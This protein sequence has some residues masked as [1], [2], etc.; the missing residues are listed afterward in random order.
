MEESPFRLVYRTQDSQGVLEV[1]DDGVTRTLYFGSRAKQ[2]SMLLGHHQVL[3]LTYTQSMTA[4]L[5]FQPEPREV[6]VIGLGGGSL[7]KFFHHHF[8]ACRVL[9]LENRP[10]VVD[11]AQRYF[12]LP[13]D[14]RLHIEMTGALEYL[15]RPVQRRFDIILVDIFDAQGMVADL[16]ERDFF[17]RCREHLSGQ[18]VLSANLW[19]TQPGTFRQQMKNLRREF[20]QQVLELPVPKCG[21]IIAFGLAQD[22]PTRNLRKL[23]VH[24]QRLEQRYGIDYPHY[25]DRMRHRNRFSLR[26]LFR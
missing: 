11:I 20:D 1:V 2:S 23:S 25:V 12:D 7:P 5:L 9:A 10:S 8:P 19:S 21:N 24:A 22:F 18:G 17:H 13:N 3:A 16:D 26:R 14:E 15:A 6:L 4:A